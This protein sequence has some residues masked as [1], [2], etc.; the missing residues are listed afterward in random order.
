[1]NLLF[2]VLSVSS[3]LIITS[4]TFLFL[5]FIQK[6]PGFGL[7]KTLINREHYPSLSVIIAACNEELTIEQTIRR[8]VNQDYPNFEVVVVN[9]R[10]TDKTGV[11][12]EKLCLEYPQ[13][14][15]VTI[16]DLPENW[17]GKTHAIY[18]GVKHSSGEWLLF[19]DADV[20][21]SPGSLKEP[22][23]YALEHNLD[24][25]AMAPDVF[26]GGILYRAFMTYI[27]IVITT[28][29]MFTK[30]AGTGAF[31]LVKRSVYDA[32]GGYKAVAMQ[33]IDDISFGELIVDK[34]YKQFLGY[35]TPGF[36]SVKWYN[37]L[38]E[39]FH[40]LEKNQFAT[41]K[42]SVAMTLTMFFAVLLIGVYPFIGIFLGPLWARILCGISIL[43]CFKIYHVAAK[44]FNV[45]RWYVF[46]HPL[47]SIFELGAAL[48]SM[49]KTLRRGGVE[50]KGKLYPIKELKRNL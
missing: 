8:L 24:H 30:K 41:A 10:S 14:K 44:R 17:L 13:L 50:W 12:L 26:N 22:V 49:I 20:L 47:S 23:H 1:M 5:K 39:T 28:L 16:T 27:S 2:S 31:N 19:T 4:L 48:N 21:F 40:G 3:V 37:N 45:S 42:F 11:I 7:S 18:E 25:L 35:S 46:L 43:C 9:D 38:W 6:L 32:V 15:V 34:G 36:I 29:M 33:V